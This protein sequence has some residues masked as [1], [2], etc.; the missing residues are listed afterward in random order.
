MLATILKVIA[1]VAFAVIAVAMFAAVWVYILVAILCL[2]A[3]VFVMWLFNSRFS[4]TKNGVKVGTYTR[5]G[6]FRRI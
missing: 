4:V 1:L 5:K 3:L 2:P 6:G